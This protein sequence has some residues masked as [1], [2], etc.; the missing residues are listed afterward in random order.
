MKLQRSLFV[1]IVLMTAFLQP[2][3][4]EASVKYCGDGRPAP[5][6]GKC[7]DSRGGNNDFYGAIGGPNG[8]SSSRNNNSYGGFGSSAPSQ[9]QMN[10]CAKNS[11]SMQKCATGR[12]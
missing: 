8:N 4:A 11:L 6:N 7:F 5:A 10:N 3:S 1:S 12:K 9:S 2:S